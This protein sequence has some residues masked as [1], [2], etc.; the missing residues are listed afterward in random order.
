MDYK[1]L[2][3]FYEE[4]D[5]VLS[6]YLQYYINKE[7]LVLNQKKEENQGN[8]TEGFKD[9]VELSIFLSKVVKTKMTEWAIKNPEEIKTTD[10]AD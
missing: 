10:F 7:W 4:L 9:S 1:Y 2:N 6:E 3:R 8:I 5:K